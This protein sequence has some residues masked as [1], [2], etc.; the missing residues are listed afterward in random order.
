MRNRIRKLFLATAMVTVPLLSTV[1][2]RLP[3]TIY[4]VD[5]YDDYYDDHS[6]FDVFLDVFD[7]GF[8]YDEGYYE[9][10]IYIDEYY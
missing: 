7:G 2:C 5:A 8:Y 4:L 10:T 9:E 1:T 6:Y 3:D